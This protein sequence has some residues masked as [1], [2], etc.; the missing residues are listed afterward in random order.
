MAKHNNGT[1]PT[2]TKT[3]ST[4][5][6]AQPPAVVST[7][8]TAASAAAPAEVPEVVAKADVP[9]EEP[10]KKSLVVI[11]TPKVPAPRPSMGAQAAL[12]DPAELD[13]AV[14]ARREVLEALLH[15]TTMPETT[16]ASLGA[17]IAL[18]STQK[19]GMEE[20]QNAWKLTRASIVQ[21][22]TRS[23]AK[24][25]SARPGDI[26]TSGGQILVRPSAVIPIY[27]FEENVNFPEGGKVPVCSA[28]DAKLGSPFGKCVDCP[29]LPYGKQNGGRGEQKKT[30]CQNNIVAVLLLKDLSG[31]FTM[32]FGKTSRKAGGVMMQ[33]A[34]QQQ[35][36]WTQSY[37]L[38]TEKKTNDAGLYYIMTTAPT[39]QNNPDD[40]CRVAEAF[41]GLYAAERKRGLADHYARPARAPIAAAEA[42][43]EFAG[44]AL[45]AGLAGDGEEPDLSAP[46]KAAGAAPARTASK[47]M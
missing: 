20:M 35:R 28:P 18:A 6:T 45:E 41:Y 23:E 15:D 22:T 2:D 3:T 30:D 12:I 40:V 37:L 4:T 25:E 32:Q 34:G 33:L 17:L 1:T 16:R 19:P 5:Q 11:D 42:E 47:P 8:A 26:Y 31:L 9:V 14:A 27:F 10:A 21:P 46:A 29:H 7:P 39:G 36:V 24:P 43:A 13:A 38:N 44:G